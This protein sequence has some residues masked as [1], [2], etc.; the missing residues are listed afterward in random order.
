MRGFLPAVPPTIEALGVTTPDRTSL[1]IAYTAGSPL[2]ASTRERFEHNW[3]VK[4]GDLYA[5]P[6]SSIRIGSWTLRSPGFPT[7]WLWDMD[8]DGNLFKKEDPVDQDEAF[9]KEMGTDADSLFKE[10]LIKQEKDQ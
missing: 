1:R 3:G 2:P 6:P 4:V 10:G 9:W 7:S 8:D 5:D